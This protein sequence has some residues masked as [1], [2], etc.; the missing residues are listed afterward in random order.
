MTLN[1]LNCADVSLNNIHPS[2]MCKNYF[3]FLALYLKNLICTYLSLCLNC[4]VVYLNFSSHVVWFP[5]L[6][7]VEYRL[8]LYSSIYYFSR[9]TCLCASKLSL[10]SRLARLTFKSGVI[11]HVNIVRGM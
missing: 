7:P 9:S 10:R 8:I 11:F 6:D 2:N 3:S 4:K 5:V 1:G